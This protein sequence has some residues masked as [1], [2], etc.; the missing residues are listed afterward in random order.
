M[1]VG[2][3]GLIGSGKDTAAEYLCS[4]HGFKRLSYAGTLKDAVAAVFHWDRNLLEGLTPESR[5]WREQVDEW[6]ANRLNIP[7]LTP[8]WVLQYWGTDLCR[9]HFHDDI[10]IASIECQLRKIDSNV[11]IS[12]CRFP[13]ELSTLKNAGGITVRI[14]RGGKPHWYLDA[15]VVSKGEK[16]P[17]YYGSIK[18]LKEAGIHASEYSSVG[19]GYDHTIINEGT[20][21][22]FYKKIDSI[23]NL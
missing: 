18:M 16:H 10:W 4:Y 17:M 11:V 7:H 8:R 5:A 9:K 1:I 3:T 21:E 12:D 22:E 14:E 2:I 19:V 13:N 6:W 20:L 23:V 15:L